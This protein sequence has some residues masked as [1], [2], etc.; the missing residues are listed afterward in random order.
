MNTQL[1]RVRTADGLELH[2]LLW[3]P[4]TPPRLAVL[5]L[6][7]L[8]GNFY[9][10]PFVEAMA[11]A[12]TETGVGFCS[13]NTRGH[14]Y[15]ADVLVERDGTVDS[16]RVGGAYDPVED[17]GLDIEAWL[18]LL[19]GDGYEVVLQGHSLG[20][21]KAARYAE[22]GD[23]RVIGL[24]LLSAPDVFGLDLAVH[25][26]ARSAELLDLARRRVAEGR[27]DDLLPADALDGYLLSARTYLAMFG[28]GT[29][30]ALFDRQGRARLDVEVPVFAAYGTEDEPIVA[31]PAEALGSLT[32]AV[33]GPPV[34][35][36]VFEGA[37]H[38]YLGFEPTVAAAVAD[39]VATRVGPSRR[40]ERYARTAR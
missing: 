7:G 15:L 29:P 35:T 14:D 38:S 39:W 11:R 3:E 17:A 40:L 9:E 30:V 36:A 26:E 6:H 22:R 37:G 21:L 2:G 5:H 34:D 20:A 27:G 23:P 4:P 16:V 24:V 13:V 10:N 25:G 28:P 31:P 32:A 19:A 8:A 1:V 33:D 12:L 18:G